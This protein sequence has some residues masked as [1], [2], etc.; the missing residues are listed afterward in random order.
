M[1]GKNTAV[2]LMCA[3]L[4]SQLDEVQREGL[5]VDLRFVEVAPI[6]GLNCPPRPC[7]REVEIGQLLMVGNRGL[8]VCLNLLSSIGRFCRYRRSADC[9]YF[10]MREALIRMQKELQAA[11][12]QTGVCRDRQVL[13]ARALPDCAC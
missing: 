7:Q 10:D 2:A 13:F 12:G 9:S 8:A 4:R 5:T 1:I 3:P 6:T 11:N